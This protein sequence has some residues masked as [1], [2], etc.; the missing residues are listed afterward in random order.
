[1]IDLERIKGN[2]SFKVL[3]HQ[4]AIEC[5]TKSLAYDACN[6]VVFANRAMAYIKTELFDLAEEDCSIA[7][8]LDNCYVK[9]FSRRGLVRFKRGRYVEV[10]QLLYGI[11]LYH[12][13]SHLV[14]NLA[15]N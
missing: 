8:L 15:N 14:A 1:V 13:L 2:E 7:L 6:A 3:E 12:S 9:A 4:T 5:Y 10:S 11:L